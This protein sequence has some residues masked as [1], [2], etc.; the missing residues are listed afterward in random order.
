MVRMMTRT[1]ETGFVP[2]IFWGVRA[3]MGVEWS[4][5]WIR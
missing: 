4:V 5:R 3:W 2:A 1:R